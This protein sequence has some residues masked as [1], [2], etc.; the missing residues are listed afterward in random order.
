MFGGELTYLAWPGLRCRKTLPLFLLFQAQGSPTGQPANPCLCVLSRGG[1]TGNPCLPAFH[2]L[3]C[4]YNSSNRLHFLLTRHQSLSQCLICMTSFNPHGTIVT[5][6]GYCYPHYFIEE[7]NYDAL[8]VCLVK[9]HRVGK[10]TLK[11]RFVWLGAHSLS[12]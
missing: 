6:G 5:I 11:S 12:H 2:P 10:L 7:K 9:G 4:G 3:C 1:T 8:R